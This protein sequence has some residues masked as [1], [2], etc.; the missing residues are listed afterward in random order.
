M[1][2]RV[3]AFGGVFICSPNPTNLIEWYQKHLGIQ[4]DGKPYFS[5][6]W[7]KANQHNEAYTAFSVFKDGNEY[8]KPSEKSYMLNFRVENL[9]NLLKLLSS[10]G[11]H[12]LSSQSELLE[13]IGKFNWIMDPD[14]NKIEL[15]E[16]LYPTTTI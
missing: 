14:G 7:N 12:P 16:Q 2:K 8:L 1:E 11:I 3:I 15:W 6:E 13:G 10:E 9:D 4:F 5:F